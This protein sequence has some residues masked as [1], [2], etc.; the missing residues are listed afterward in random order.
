MAFP[1]SPTNG[2]QVTLDSITYQYDSGN[3]AWLRVGVSTVTVPQIAY[4]RTSFTST[5]GQVTFST[6]YTPGYIQIFINGVLLGPDDYIGT[7]GSSVTLNSQCNAGDLVEIISFVPSTLVA[8]SVSASNIV[9]Q[10][11]ASQII[12]IA[13]TQLTGVI[14]SSQLSTTTVVA[15]TYGNTTS[16]PS[17]TVGTDGRVTSIS[18]VA[19]STGTSGLSAARTLINTMVFGG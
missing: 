7:S 12:S 13:N 8:N 15:G 1:I 9:G 17:I 6:T 3:T 5:Q 18:N 19:I 16:I 11:T 10:I 2:Q 14:N 4:V